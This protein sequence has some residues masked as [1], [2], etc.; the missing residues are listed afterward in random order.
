MAPG[1][2]R[3]GVAG[4]S[5]VPGPDAGAALGSATVEVSVRVALR[6]GPASA[7]RVSG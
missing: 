5:A 3:P 7:V 6:P 2:R 1:P 4:D